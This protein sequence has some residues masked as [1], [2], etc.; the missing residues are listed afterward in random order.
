MTLVRVA[1]SLFDCLLDLSLSAARSP[2]SLG[3][4]T[5][6]VALHQRRRDIIYTTC[7]SGRHRHFD[8]PYDCF[9]NRSLHSLTQT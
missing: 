9:V 6:F 3:V 7:T 5:S 8:K 1:D 4:C 2:C